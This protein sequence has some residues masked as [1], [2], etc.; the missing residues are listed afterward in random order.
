M[1]KGEGKG[2]GRRGRVSK[3]E[4]GLA[5]V[6]KIIGGRGRKGRRRENIAGGE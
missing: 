1:G 6:D 3:R 5:V 4:G 2:R